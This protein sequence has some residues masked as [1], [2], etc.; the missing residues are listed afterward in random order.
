MHSADDHF[1]Q[2]EVLAAEPK[3]ASVETVLEGYRAHAY[4]RE[5]LATVEH[6]LFLAR[7]R[8][9]ATSDQVFDSIK[10]GRSAFREDWKQ[11][12]PGE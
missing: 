10:V 5:R 6:G 9:G 11:A 1:R 4:E 12:H 7:Q 3:T 8:T 2:V